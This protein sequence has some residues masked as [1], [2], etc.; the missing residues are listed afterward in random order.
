MHQL[1][2]KTKALMRMIRAVTTGT[3]AGR[4]DASP[5][6]IKPPM[7]SPPLVRTP[8]VLIAKRNAGNGFHR[9]TAGSAIRAATECHALPDFVIRAISQRLASQTGLLA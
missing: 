6:G 5:N 4:R 1:R 2:T 3:R 7:Q 8:L 9:S